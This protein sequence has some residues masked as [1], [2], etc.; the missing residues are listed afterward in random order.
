MTNYEK[1]KNLS[2]D[3]LIQMISELAADIALEIV[4]DYD[5]KAEINQH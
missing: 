1:L 3:G 2:K 5:D 4:N